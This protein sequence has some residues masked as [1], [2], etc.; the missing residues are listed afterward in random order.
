MGSATEPDR[1]RAKTSPVLLDHHLAWAGVGPGDS[2]VDFGCASGEVVR[3]AAARS[4]TG[5]ILGL[6]G[7]PEMLR[8]AA[9]ESDRIGLDIEY[10]RADIAGEGSTG[11]PSGEFDHSWARWFIEYLPDPHAVVREMT[12]VVAPGAH[13]TLIDLEGNA[14]WHH[15]TTPEFRANVDEVMANLAR[16]GFDPHAGARLAEYARGAGLVDVREQVEPYHWVVGRPDQAAADAW[17]AKVHGLKENY[18]RRIRPDQPDMAAFFD[19]FLAFVMDE[20]TMT[21]SLA[22]LVQGTKPR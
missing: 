3:A 20:N 7:D 19:E 16:T 11:L 14:V 10:L 22:H 18:V 21:W 1:I 9:E 4:G 12:R 8:F 5:R 15:P 17:T 6:D 13:V 2:F